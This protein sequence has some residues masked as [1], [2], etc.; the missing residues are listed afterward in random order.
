M[1]CPNQALRYRP[2]GVQEEGERKAGPAVWV[3]RD[4]RPV[5]ANV[6]TGLDDETFTEILGGDLKAG[7]AV[8]VG[9]ARGGPSNRGATPAPRL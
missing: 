6:T 5:P 4:G 2:A 3:L 1:P 9:E 8:I 7:D